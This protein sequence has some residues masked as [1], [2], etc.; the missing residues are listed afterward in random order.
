MIDSQR[1]YQV[2]FGISGLQIHDSVEHAR[3]VPF[4]LRLPYIRVEYRRSYPP[5]NG[6][7]FQALCACIWQVGCLVH[8]MLRTDLLSEDQPAGRKQDFLLI[9]CV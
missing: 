2:S 3:N 9:R 5:D 1:T 7:L 4:R 8:R 6:F